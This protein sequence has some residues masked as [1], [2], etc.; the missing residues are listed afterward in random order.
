M[1]DCESLVGVGNWAS[2]YQFVNNRLTCGNISVADENAYLLSQNE[3]ESAFPNVGQRPD[4]GVELLEER[5]TRNARAELLQ[6][7]AQTLELAATSYT[8]FIYFLVK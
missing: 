4:S 2:V 5:R 6:S 8:I 1:R 7:V 3:F